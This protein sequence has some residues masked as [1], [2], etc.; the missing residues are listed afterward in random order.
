MRAGILPGLSSI[1]GRNSEIAKRLDAKSDRKGTLLILWLKG[2][3]FN[4]IQ[5]YFKL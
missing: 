2:H 1:S 5:N 4:Y 3:Y